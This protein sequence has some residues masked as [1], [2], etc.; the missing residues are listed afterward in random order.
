[1]FQGVLSLRVR[2]SREMRI[3]LA[4]RSHVQR[5]VQKR[6]PGHAHHIDTVLSCSDDVSTLRGQKREKKVR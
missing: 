2:N 5:V 3:L 4:R 1:M 6:L